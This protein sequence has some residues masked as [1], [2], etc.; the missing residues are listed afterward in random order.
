MPTINKR[1]LLIC[2]VVFVAGSGVLFGIHAIQSSRI[3]GALLRQAARA[4]ELGHHDTAIRYLRQYL[5]FRP[6][7]LD[8]RMELAERLKNRGST[9]ELPF[10]YDAILRAD[11][12]RHAVRRDAVAM[13]L[14]L[15]RFTD[16]A[17]HAEKLI[18]LDPN[19]GQAWLQLADARAALHRNDDAVKAY[20][21][22][23]ALSPN[24]PKPFRDY[25]YWL[26][27]EGTKPALAL[28]VADRFVAAFPQ[29]PEPYVAR[30]RMKMAE[31]ES[32]AADVR[33]DLEKARA[34]APDHAE[35]LVYYADWLQRAGEPSAARERLVEGTV[36]HP[37]DVR[38]FRRLAWLDLHR[39]NPIAAVTTL[40]AGLKSV[41]NGF[42]E[43]LVPL[44][45]LLVQIGETK[46]ADEI[47]AQL[48]AR[49]G[50]VP[51]VQAKYLSARLAMRAGDW[52]KAV[53][54]LTTLRTETV[55]IP[56]LASQTNLLLAICSRQT[57]NP[58]GERDSLMLVLNRDPKHVPAR[59]ALAQ[60]YLA[61]GDLANAIREYDE[62]AASPY[63]SGSTAA[64]AVRLKAVRISL[65]GVARPQDWAEL[66]RKA[67][68]TA[69]K[70]GPAS[71]EPAILR[72][73]LVGRRGEPARAVAM[74]RQELTRRSRDPHVWTALADWTSMAVGVAAGLA[75]C[76]E[77]TIVVG[78]GPDVRITRAKLMSR[79][80]LKMYP[81]DM[82]DRQIDG[83]IETDQ[84][85]LL[86]GLINAADAMDDPKAVVRFSRRLAARRANDP[87]AWLALAEQNA[88]TNDEKTA[89][90]VRN[91]IVRLEGEQGKNVLLCD[92]RA[93]L[94]GADASR[95]NAWKDRLNAS[96]G[97]TP[98]RADACIVLAQLFRV[99]GDLPAATTAINRAIAI[100]PSGYQTIRAAL[101]FYAETGNGDATKS[102]LN[103]LT[104]DPR[105]NGEPMQRVVLAA[106]TPQAGTAMIP[107]LD[108]LYRFEPNRLT[109]LGE[110]SRRAGKTEEA[111]QF[112]RLACD[113]PTAN[114]DDFL[115]A[116]ACFENDPP[117]ISQ[118][119][120]MAEK[121][122]PKPTYLS[123]VA[124]FTASASGKLWTPTLARDDQ[125]ALL[126]ARVQFENSR[127]NPAAAIAVLATVENDSSLMPDD[128]LW[129]SRTR[130]ILLA[131]RGTPEDRRTAA[132]IL[133]KQS[134]DM[135]TAE[136]K[137]SAAATLVALHRHLDGEDRARVLAKAAE[138]LTGSNAVRDPYLLFQI[139]RAAGDPASRDKARTLLA[140]LLKTDPNN[141]EYLVAGL[142]ERVEAAAYEAAEPFAV[143]LRAHHPTDYRAVASLAR[144]ECAAGRP[145]RVVPLV[146]TYAR[147]ADKNPTELLSRTSRAA[148]LLDELS[149]R[150]NVKST[151]HAAAI[152]NASVAKYASLLPGRIEALSAAAGLLAASGRTTEAF[153]F[154]EKYAGTTT[155]RAKAAAGVAILRSGDTSDLTVRT[156]RTWLDAALADDPES[157]AV[158]LT[159]GEF[160]VLTG[161]APAA[162]RAYQSVLDRDPQNSV[163]LNN[164]AWILSPR[165][166]QAERALS[167][168]EEAVKE[169]G[170]T[171]EL[172]DTRARIRI[173]S[174]QPD[175]AE[176]DLHAALTQE[177][178]PL[179]YFHLAMAKRT[180]SPPQLEEAK[181][182]FRNALD[183]G[184]DSHMVHPA[185]VSF[186]RTF[187]SGMPN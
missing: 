77:A 96:F 162:E 173:A 27:T 45:D 93:A 117:A 37:A 11:S 142:D 15:G 38:F 123:I 163:A 115:R 68:A 185:D 33:H 90:F 41:Q 51:Q 88:T 36:K 131:A 17:E 98:N 39:G 32:A 6:D 21:K 167:L 132:T 178:T 141:V 176:R 59:I 82:L 13:A 112:F 50:T 42:D 150:P 127:N 143:T 126:R 72:A 101:R 174:K 91:Q 103:R 129:A 168:V 99:A 177:Q 105:W 48:S 58:A 28:A 84:A 128:R 130:A 114:A 86:D 110:C 186:Y 35:A 85:R 74:L 9:A 156:A 95:A 175:L 12:T 158:R 78:D 104:V 153:G 80:P 47:V 22:A 66:D 64:M 83:W 148:D 108:A 161:N 172:L 71:A 137:R 7:D 107:L 113:R 116:L 81:L 54:L 109:W 10:L 75:V 157:T 92:A 34:L 106:M 44:G 79:D 49:K 125:F 171:P 67:A 52:T 181:K 166:D 120:A 180:A 144:Y 102:L 18:E 53:D 60:S 69:S 159:E 29:S 146:E 1:F 152:V 65:S 89:R 169:S 184:L 118:F 140:E 100:D 30:A 87:I 14:K 182:A 76:D 151:P 3:P 46:R 40:E 136:E 20:E 179:R 170:L 183:R 8:V 121:R 139:H 147:A 24:D 73:E 31:G 25:H 119:M 5:E 19:D 165:P 160:F 111:K 55:A 187:V 57:G 164:L 70:Y 122:F 16:A 63:S 145:E 4:G 155:S 154:V 133:L 94:L 43:L 138:L 56:G 135:G 134:P 23:I 2:V 61:S 26:W 97:S 62:A 149:R 124:A